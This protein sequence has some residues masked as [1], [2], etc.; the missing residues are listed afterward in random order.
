MN[1][2]APSQVPGLRGLTLDEATQF[3]GCRPEHVV[4]GPEGS[5]HFDGTILVREQLGGETLLY[6]RL[7]DA[8]TVVVR[9]DGD[10]TTEP[11]TTIGLEIPAHRLHRFDADGRAIP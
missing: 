4:I 8:L 11:G 10:N 5:G 3:I 1:V 6:A 7:S 2:F 9:T